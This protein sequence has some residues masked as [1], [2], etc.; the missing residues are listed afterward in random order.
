MKKKIFIHYDL[1]GGR[2]LLSYGQP[3]HPIRS[4]AWSPDGKRIASGSA[5]KAVRVWDASSGHT[6]LTYR[7]HLDVVN[8]VAWS[9]DGKR[10]ASASQDETVQVWLW[11]ES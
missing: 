1:S 4:V 10:L 6:L 2:L 7:R 3:T 8:S 9:P 11:L 5:D